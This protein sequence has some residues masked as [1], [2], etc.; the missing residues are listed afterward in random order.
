[1]AYAVIKT[2]GRQYR[3]EQG[4][5]IEVD[6]LEL[7]TGATATFEVLL[8]GEGD[9]VKVG[10]PL[11]EGAKVEAEVMEQAKGEKLVAFK[12]KRRKGYHRT[13]GHRQ[14]LTRIKITGIHS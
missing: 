14:K 2:G 7:D 3:V 12:F 6:K 9:S 5:V 8:A 11:L 13:V 1:M 4:D 10:T